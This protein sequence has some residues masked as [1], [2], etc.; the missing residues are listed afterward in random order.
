MLL[1]V[2]GGIKQPQY[3]EPFAIQIQCYKWKIQT[4]WKRVQCFPILHWKWKCWFN[5]H[6]CCWHL[7]K[8]LTICEGHETTYFTGINIVCKMARKHVEGH[9]ESVQDNE[10]NV[11]NLQKPNWIVEYEWYLQL[12]NHILFYTIYLFLIILWKTF[13]HDPFFFIFQNE[14][15]EI[16]Q[17]MI[18][19]SITT[20]IIIIQK[21][22]I[23][24][25]IQTLLSGQFNKDGWNHVTW[26]NTIA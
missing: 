1:M 3:T 15:A 12:D 20:P 14:K 21:V 4:N 16:G 18:W 19:R 9:Q 25:N 2:H 11:E 7:S 23:W 22:M 6:S 17:K 24:Q 10:I 8:S 5:L 13:I 26:K